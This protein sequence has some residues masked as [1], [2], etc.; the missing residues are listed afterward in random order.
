M[1][2]KYEKVDKLDRLTNELRNAV[3]LSE[4]LAKSEIE[5]VTV[6]FAGRPGTSLT[7]VN[8]Y[9]KDIMEIIDQRLKERNA[10]IMQYLDTIKVPTG[11][12]IMTR[13]QSNK[14]TTNQ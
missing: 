1:T 11:K 2:N 7:E 12:D 14:E 13:V 10:V 4:T 9:D 5:R 8:I 3:K 6:H